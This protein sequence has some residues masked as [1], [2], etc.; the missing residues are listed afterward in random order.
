[1]EITDKEDKENPSIVH[2]FARKSFYG[3]L[4]GKSP[5]GNY[6]HILGI[7]NFSNIVLIVEDLHE[8]YAKERVELANNLIKDHGVKSLINL[9]K[10]FV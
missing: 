8:Y 7:T 3:S 10:V 6:Y 9:K 5:Y 2:C 4:N 1:M